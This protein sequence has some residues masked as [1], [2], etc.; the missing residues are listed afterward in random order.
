MAGPAV[1]S[2]DKAKKILAE[3]FNAA[4]LPANAVSH[5]HRGKHGAR[6]EQ[7]REDRTHVSNHQSRKEMEVACRDCCP[8]Y[9]GT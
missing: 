6:I 1:S 7:R 3:F 8:L 5:H 9:V 4:A 2:S